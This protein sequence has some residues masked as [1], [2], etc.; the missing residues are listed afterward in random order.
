LE[1]YY[2]NERQKKIVE[3]SR[4]W[5]QKT[6]MEKG[7]LEGEFATLLRPFEAFYSAEEN[8]QDYYKKNPIRYRYYRTSC[9]RD[10]RL[11]ELW[12]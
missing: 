7:R 1:E 10:K 8:H 12:D 5:A 4:D 2:A 9:G 11:K 6:L 3:D